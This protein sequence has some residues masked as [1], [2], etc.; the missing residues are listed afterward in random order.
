M[1]ETVMLAPG[2]AWMAGADLFVGV[3][4]PRTEFVAPIVHHGLAVDV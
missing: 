4:L 1:D 3:G 2:V